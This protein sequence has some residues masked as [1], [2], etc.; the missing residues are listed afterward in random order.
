MRVSPLGIAGAMTKLKVTD[1]DLSAQF[2]QK[3]Q[4]SAHKLS[5]PSFVPS[6]SMNS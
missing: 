3:M 1:E 6:G 2:L 4:A 5:Y